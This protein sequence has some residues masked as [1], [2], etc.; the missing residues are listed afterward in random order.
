MLLYIEQLIC[1]ILW[2][3]SIKIS[4][5]HARLYFQR[6]INPICQTKIYFLI[7]LQG[8]SWYLAGFQEEIL[9]WYFLN[10]FSSCWTNQASVDHSLVS[11]TNL[12]QP[13]PPNLTHQPPRCI[14]SMRLSLKKLS[15]LRG[16]SKIIWLY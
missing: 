2:E 4:C 6:Y 10:V 1:K 16:K 9:D 12:I 11:Q 13:K 8:F 5:Q 15:F 3:H 7:S 14:T